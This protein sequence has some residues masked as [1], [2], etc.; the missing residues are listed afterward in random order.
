[1]FKLD[2]KEVR[3]VIIFGAILFIWFN[4]LIKKFYEIANGNSMLY[5]FLFILVYSGFIAYFIFGV[6]PLKNPRLVFA[7]FLAFLLGDLLIF[8]LLIPMDKPPILTQETIYS[9]DIFIYNF[10]KDLNVSDIIKYNLVYVVAGVLILLIIG[11]LLE[12]KR[13]TDALRSVF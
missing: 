2:R 13:F 11:F 4:F 3:I 5:Y 1:M 8:P 12:G 10:I 6:H 9:S 7:Y